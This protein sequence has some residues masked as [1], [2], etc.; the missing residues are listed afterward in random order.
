[1]PGGAV[2]LDVDGTLVDT[3][4]QHALAWFR[5]LRTE[6]VTVPIWQLHRAIGM[7][8]DR[9]VEHVAGR[10][11][12]AAHGDA[13]RKNWKR[14]FEEMIDEIAPL[15]GAHELLVT[16]KRHGL[17]LV[18]ASSGDPVHVEHYRALLDAEALTDAT[19]TAADADTTKPAPDLIEVATRAV[20]A[21]EAV[22]IGDSPW[23]CVAAR[24]AGLPSVG[25]RTGGFTDGELREAGALRVFSAL[26][27]L[28]EAIADL[29]F[30][31]INR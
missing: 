28:G 26:P 27:V 30:A 22:V 5:A 16:I 3:N 20:S 13:I 18:L 23:D 14:E 2:L 24:R 4:Y 17:L 25:V 11:V 15:A 19:T 7:G 29:P 9:L 31:P 21:D 1:V 12:E 6:G 8:G 10:E